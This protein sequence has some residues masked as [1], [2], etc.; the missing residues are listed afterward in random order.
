MGAMV[1]PGCVEEHGITI[2]G[3][4]QQAKYILVSNVVWKGGGHRRRMAQQGELQ[5]DG[6]LFV[7]VIFV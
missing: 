4:L 1:L 3:Y 6:M 5:M 7:L 2:S